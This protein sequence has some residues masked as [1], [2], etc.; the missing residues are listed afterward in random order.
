[1]RFL[2]NDAAADAELN[3]GRN[4]FSHLISILIVE[5]KECAFLLMALALIYSCSEI[6]YAMTQLR[7]FVWFNPAVTLCQQTWFLFLKH[8]FLCES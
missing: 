3:T 6:K 1:M 8:I 5:R 2:C 4:F 7:R